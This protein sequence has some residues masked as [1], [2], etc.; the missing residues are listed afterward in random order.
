MCQSGTN[1]SNFTIG[2]EQ[3]IF[4]IKKWADIWNILSR[5]IDHSFKATYTYSLLCLPIGLFLWLWH[6]KI[7][8][9]ERL[10]LWYG[11]WILHVPDDVEHELNT[12]LTALQT[13]RTRER[14]LLN[15]RVKTLVKIIH[16]EVV[17]VDVTVRAMVNPWINR[18]RVWRRCNCSLLV[19]LALR[20]RCLGR[21]NLVLPI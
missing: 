9:L 16:R 11:V 2:G 7:R 17:K 4:S 19:A 1:I 12:V 18:W 20:V 13:R 5:V 3:N 8:L 21:F 14:I 15:G 10:V 6:H